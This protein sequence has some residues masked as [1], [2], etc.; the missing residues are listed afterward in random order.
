MRR[1]EVPDWGLR[2]I[3][4]FQAIEK[5]ALAEGTKIAMTWVQSAYQQGIYGLVVNLGSIAARTLLQPFEEAAFLAFSRPLDPCK[6]ATQKLDVLLPLVKI[7]MLFGEVSA[8]LSFLSNRAF[9][10]FTR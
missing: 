9:C 7:A 5:L 1:E 8:S 3:S 4:L 10:T 2:Q 6:P